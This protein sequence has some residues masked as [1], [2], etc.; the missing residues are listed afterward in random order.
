M[1]GLI[2]SFF[3]VCCRGLVVMMVLLVLLDLP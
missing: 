1:R 2:N 3:P